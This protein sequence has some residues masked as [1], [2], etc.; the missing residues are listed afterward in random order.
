[1]NTILKTLKFFEYYG[2]VRAENIKKTT[3][4]AVHRLLLGD[5]T[6]SF[7]TVLEYNTDKFNLEFETLKK[8]IYEDQ[9]ARLN[10]SEWI[11][12]R[13]KGSF[14]KKRKEVNHMEN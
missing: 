14:E 3:E 10:Q 6:N 11:D 7:Q 13:L 9:E 4:I 1:M 2:I 8:K 5:M 12:V